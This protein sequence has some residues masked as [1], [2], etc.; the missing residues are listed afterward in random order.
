[1][2]HV[3]IDLL[4]CHVV[5]SSAAKVARMLQKIYLF[6]VCFGLHLIIKYTFLVLSSNS[7]EKCYS[8]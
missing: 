8:L 3:L 2:C 6:H 4:S 1:M 7:F 5:I